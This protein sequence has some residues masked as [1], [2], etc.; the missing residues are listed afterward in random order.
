M[1]VQQNSS[2]LIDIVRAAENGYFGLAPFQRNYVWT[3]DDV[4]KLMKSVV[5]EWPLGAFTTWEPVP[6]E[7]GLYPSRGRLGP[8]KHPE[9]VNTLILDGQNRLASL[10]YASRLHDAD[11]A[12]DYSA[13]E[14]E[15]WFGD[16]I[17]AIDGARREVL[18]MPREEAWGPTCMPFGDVMDAM[19]FRK[20]TRSVDL[21]QKAL[22]LG[23]DDETLDWI[24][25]KLPHSVL[26]ARVVVTNL[27]HASFEEAKECYMT[28]CRAGQ[29]ISDA[30]FEMAFSYAPPAR[31]GMRP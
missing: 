24:T 30:E 16:E 23:M 26:T 1:R 19:I 29:P 28:I 18:F 21:Y 10:I 27:M 22:S 17:L 13:E 14:L 12:A 6:E 31:E 9:L 5:R 3:R 2:F 7:R 20:R 15:V 4:L 25:D 11:P 8:V